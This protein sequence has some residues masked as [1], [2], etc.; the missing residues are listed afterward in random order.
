MDIKQLQELIAMQ[1]KEITS[2]EGSLNEAFFNQV[3]KVIDE[4]SELNRLGGEYRAIDPKGANKMKAYAKR[5]I[6]NY[7]DTYLGDVK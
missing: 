3:E 1:I 7:L 6:S 4:I 2:D 5:K